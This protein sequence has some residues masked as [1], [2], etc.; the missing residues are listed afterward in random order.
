MKNPRLLFLLFALMQTPV[1]VFSQIQLEHTYSH[2][3]TFTKLSNSGFK[4]FVMDVGQNQCRIYNTDHTL[5]KTINLSVPGNQYLYDIQYI[6][7]NLFTLDNSLC[8]VY[9]Y[10]AYDETNLYYTYT[11]RVIKENG[12]LLLEIPGCQYYYVTDIE[13]TGSEFVTYSYDYSIFPYTIETAVY[14]LPG[15]LVTSIQPDQPTNAQFM[16]MAP[17]PATDFIT[18]SL[19]QTGKLPFD[20]VILSDIQGNAVRTIWIKDK[21]E[22]LNIP[23]NGLSRGVY[24]C[25]L[26]TDNVMVNSQKIVVQ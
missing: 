1:F 2:S 18:I 12:T 13:Q 20:K 4:F 6:S 23:L 26:F 11:T 7:E 24:I 22:Q 16:S 3:G 14:R 10:Y 9:T 21:R 15:E 8:L 17:N 25:S 5:W 19:D